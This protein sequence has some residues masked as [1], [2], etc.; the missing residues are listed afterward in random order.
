MDTLD[1]EAF[2]GGCG[3]EDAVGDVADFVFGA[4]FE[5]VA[6]SVIA[7]RRPSA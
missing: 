4:V 3:D 2:G 5:A 1:L 7:A 6:R